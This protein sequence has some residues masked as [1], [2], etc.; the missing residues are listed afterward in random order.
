MVLGCVILCVCYA[1]VLQF[2]WVGK[3][4]LAL[5]FLC[6]SIML[7]RC[8]AVY[9]C[10]GFCLRCGVVDLIDFVRLVVAGWFWLV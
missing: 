7:L 2:M 4:V 1:F 5:R 10:R 8:F 9:A 6:C 3:F